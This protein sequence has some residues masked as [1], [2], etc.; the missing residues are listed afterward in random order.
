MTDALC[1]GLHAIFDSRYAEHVER[2]QALCAICPRLAACEVERQAA[3]DD[4]HRNGAL[5]PEGTWAGVVHG[6]VIHPCGTVQGYYR[7]RS[8]GEPTCRECSAA[9]AAVDRRKYQRRKG[10]A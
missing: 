10:A 3:I 9:R 2:A 5:M 6:R 8:N 7:H 1:A 4:A